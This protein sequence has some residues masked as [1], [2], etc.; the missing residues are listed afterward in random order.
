MTRSMAMTRTIALGLLLAPA[1]LCRAEQTVAPVEKAGNARAAI[2]RGVEW[3]QQNQGTNG[4]WSNAKFPALTAL[5]LWA[6]CASG[7]TN[8]RAVVDHAVAYI[9]RCVQTNGGIYVDAPGQKGGGLP[10]YNTAICMTAL[11]ATGRRDLAPVVLN[12]RTYVAQSQHFGDDVYSGGFG[13]DRST[14]RAYTDLDNTF[15]ALEAMRLTQ[16]AEDLRPS[17]QKRADVNWTAA[18]NYVSKLQNPAAAGTNDAGGFAYSPDDPKA[19]LVTN[20][21]GRV[22]LRS[23]GSITYVGLLSMIYADVTRADPRVTS[24]VDFAARHWTLDENPGM[25]LQGLYFYFNVMGRALD[26]AGFNAVPRKTGGG[27][28]AWRREL[29]A[30]LAALQRPDGSWCN[31]N[32]RFWEGDPVLATAYAVLA[33]EYASGKAL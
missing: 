23:F 27:E 5:P 19:G 32:N 8:R 1:G 30:K 29:A 6:I 31:A 4:A 14:G 21:E 25:G 12:A 26:T 7:E 24:A 11:H 2:L 17:S 33:L 20:A 10:N 28:I 3:L 18:L 22:F 15:Y 16:S 9:L 13:Y